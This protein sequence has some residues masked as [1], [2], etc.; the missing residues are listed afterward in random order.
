LEVGLTDL[1]GT[2]INLSDRTDTLIIANDS[3]HVDKLY[4]GYYVYCSKLFINH[5]DYDNKL[6]PIKVVYDITMIDFYICDDIST[7]RYQ[8]MGE[9][10]DRNTIYLGSYG[11]DTYNRTKFKRIKN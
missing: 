1:Y 6:H 2:F 5:T 11:T 7:N 9:L 10:I 8:F 4:D 3:N